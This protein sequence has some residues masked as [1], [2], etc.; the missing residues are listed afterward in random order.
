MPANDYSQRRSETPQEAAD[1]RARR[2]R[3]VSRTAAASRIGRPRGSRNRP[4]TDA[5]AVRRIGRPKGALNKATRDVRT[6][7]TLL[8]EKHVPKMDR[9][10]ERVAKDDPKSAL[11]LIAKL[12]DFI[13][14]KLQRVEVRPLP[15]AL[16]DEEVDAASA[17]EVYARILG[18]PGMDLSRLRFALPAIEHEPP[19]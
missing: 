14:P 19:P 18:E 5:P 6:A 13:V 12:A 3:P 7:F 15:P 2:P 16:P 17:A 11:E 4:K 9:W 10:L 1:P 8:V